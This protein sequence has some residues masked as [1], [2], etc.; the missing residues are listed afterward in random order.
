M[1]NLLAFTTAAIF[2]SIGLLHVYWALGGKAASPSAIPTQAGKLRFTPTPAMTL[3]VALALFIA[4]LVVL[5]TVD[6]G[7]FGLPV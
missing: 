2:F 1:I 3:L 4:A 6:Y 7:R 5:G